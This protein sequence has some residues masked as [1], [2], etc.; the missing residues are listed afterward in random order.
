MSSNIEI[1]A[2]VLL[3]VEEYERIIDVLSLVKYR[4]VKQIN[5]YIDTKDRF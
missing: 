1:E 5:Y 2:K 4:K 3:N